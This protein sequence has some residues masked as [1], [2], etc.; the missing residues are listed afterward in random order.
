MYTNQGVYKC[1]YSKLN[2]VIVALVVLL[3]TFS[4]GQL[5][6]SSRGTSKQTL[7]SNTSS[8]ALKEYVI[9]SIVEG[10]SQDSDN[11]RVR[12]HLG[13]ILATTDVQE[14]GG[15]YTGVEFWRVIMSDTQRV[16]FM[17]ANP[18]V[19][20]SG[21]RK[22]LETLLLM[23]TKAQV[24]EN[25]Q[26]LY[27]EDLGLSQ[28]YDQKASG[29]EL[30]PSGNLNET[31]A[32]SGLFPGIIFQAD[33]PSDLRVVSWAP[34]VP[35][36]NS[37]S[38]AYDAESNG[39]SV[40]YLIENGIDERSRVTNRN[41]AHVL[42]VLIMWSGIHVATTRL[43]IRPQCYADRDRRR[44]TLSWILRCVEGHRPQKWSCQNGQTR[45]CEIL[46][47]SYGHHLGFSIYYQ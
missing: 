23:K 38:Y 15:E 8:D 31:S 12:L 37:K 6:L 32:A 33:A 5:V 17:S 18:K 22:V 9:Y 29:P 2:V 28:N 1:L 44:S 43:G 26:F 42:V 10:S 34:R 16:A 35:F 21:T 3:N 4:T 7:P 11:E 46:T 45:G 41:P 47:Q 13:M 30:S 14:Y 19:C 27:H 24:Q 20:S 25:T 36:G 39:Q 40:I